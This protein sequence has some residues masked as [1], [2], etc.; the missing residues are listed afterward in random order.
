MCSGFLSSR[1]TRVAD[2][3]VSRVR[4]VTLHHVD[5][6]SLERLK[7]GEDAVSPAFSQQRVGRYPRSAFFNTQLLSNTM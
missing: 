7:A 2:G 6:R 4:A 5:G 1:G 3:A